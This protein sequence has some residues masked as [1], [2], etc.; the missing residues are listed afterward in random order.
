MIDL[1]GIV[2]DYSGNLALWLFPVLGALGILSFFLL[3]VSSDEKFAKAWNTATLVLL[4]FIG[5]WLIIGGAFVMIDMPLHQL[6]DAKE[7]RILSQ[8]EEYGYSNIEV[9][10][11]KLEFIASDEG[12]YFHGVLYNRSNNKYSIIEVPSQ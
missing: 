9:D 1:N 4:P 10:M 3:L 2:L 5:L 6:E 12:Q 11:N 7:K 8:L